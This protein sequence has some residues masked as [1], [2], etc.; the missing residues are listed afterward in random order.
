MFDV[1]WP[2]R[3]IYTEQWVHEDMEVA[4]GNLTFSFVHT[5]VWSAL[6]QEWKK[7]VKLI[8]VLTEVWNRDL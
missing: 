3:I 1:K 4:V 5:F 7:S 2:S 6:G 8:G